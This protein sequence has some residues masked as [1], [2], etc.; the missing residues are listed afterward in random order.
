VRP[1]TGRAIVLAAGRKRRTIKCVNRGAVFGSDRNVERTIGPALRSDPE[2]W[3]T[4]GTAT[5]PP[6]V[7]SGPTSM[8]SV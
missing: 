8:I 1:Q 5:F 6:S 3:L 4:A 2:I 7:W